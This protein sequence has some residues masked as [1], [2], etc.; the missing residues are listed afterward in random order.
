MKNIFSFLTGCNYLSFARY[1]I[2]SSFL[3]QLLIAATLH[4]SCLGRHSTIFDIMCVTS[5]LSLYARLGFSPLNLSLG[6]AFSSIVCLSIVQ[7]NSKGSRRDWE[8][9]QSLLE[10]LI[11]PFFPSLVNSTKLEGLFI[12]LMR[13]I[14]IW[15]VFSTRCNSGTFLSEN[16]TQKS[17]YSLSAISMVFL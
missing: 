16:I 4:C 9:T 1:V 5:W 12:S 6:W 2:P 3:K 7:R 11:L 8:N 17:N 13:Y 15:I 10:T 14:W